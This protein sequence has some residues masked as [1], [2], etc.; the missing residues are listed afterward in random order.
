METPAVA[1]LRLEAALAQAAQAV[2]LTLSDQSARALTQTSV[3]SVVLTT[4]PKTNQPILIVQVGDQRI[5]LPVPA[6]PAV[7]KVLEV[8]PQIPMQL[9]VTDSG[10]VILTAQVQRP[11]PT[12]VVLRGAVA[13]ST[14]SA[15]TVQAPGVSPLPQAVSALAQVTPERVTGVLSNQGP[16]P[17][18]SPV[19]MG[20]QSDSWKPMQVARSVAE[21]IQSVGGGVKPVLIPDVSPAIPRPMAPDA[22]PAQVPIRQPIA[23][24]LGLKAGQVV[25]ALIASSKGQQQ[26]QLGNQQLPLPQ[27][28]QLPEGQ[29]AMRVVQTAQ[30][31]A[32]TP[33]LAAAQPQTAQSVAVSGL[34]AALASVIAKPS[35]RPV[36]QSLFAAG[37]MEGQLASA[38]LAKEAQLLQ[39]NRLS[40]QQLSGQQIAAAVKF[41]GLMNEKAIAEGIGFQG[42]MLKPWLRQLLRL[43]PHQ[44][45][46]SIKIGDLI[47]ELESFQLE[48]LPQSGTRDHGLS[49]LLL[50][51]DQPPVE[52]IFERHEPEDEGA[53]GALWVV[54]LHTSLESLGDVWLRSGFSGSM[55][56]MM[57][58][59]AD[60]QT[61]SLAKGARLDLEEALSEQG[62]T[63][64]SLQIFDVPR[65]GHE[66]LSPGGLPHTDVSA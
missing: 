42:G 41:G 17:S 62:L 34:S 20:V 63:V 58:W 26:M 43:L 59:A 53:N 65:P 13:P 14:Q 57:F 47:G 36:T 64:K 23:N 19:S 40:S 38:G 9:Q 46:L 54:N 12:L 37:A 29:V 45:E 10:E 56:E 60:P 50:F 7:L 16:L 66:H 27:G 30:G 49:A 61:A 52:L 22:M 18:G 39:A 4:E 44:S 48:S 11:E 33:Q 55:V 2:R 3:E 35:A 1:A 32:L 24:E 28:M 51:R 5:T 31:L 15:Q 8:N 21:S 6:S 25:Q